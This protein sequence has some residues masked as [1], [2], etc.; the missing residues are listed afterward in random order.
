MLGFRT[1]SLFIWAGNIKLAYISSDCSVLATSELYFQLAILEG[2]FSKA[3]NLYYA[4]KKIGLRIAVDQLTAWI[5]NSDEI[6]QKR[7]AK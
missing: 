7:L 1:T 5:S 4:A 3:N 2:T 6:Q